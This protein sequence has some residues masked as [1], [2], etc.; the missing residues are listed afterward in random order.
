MLKE[1]SRCIK[2][3][4]HLGPWVALG[5]G[6]RAADVFRWA[7]ALWLCSTVARLRAW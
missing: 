4:V 5:E 6:G 7:S 2:V 3:S 1:Y